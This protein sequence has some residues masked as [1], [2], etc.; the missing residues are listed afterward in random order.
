M[1]EVR[2]SVLTLLRSLSDLLKVISM[3]EY[4]AVVGF[5]AGRRYANDSLRQSQG[6]AAQ[7]TKLLE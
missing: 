3:N 4:T 6:I 2:F 1:E 7:P 5:C